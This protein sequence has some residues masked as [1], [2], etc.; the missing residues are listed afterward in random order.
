MRGVIKDAESILVLD[1]IHGGR[2]IEEELRSLGKE[3]V[4]MNPYRTLYPP[5]RRFD[6]IISP[7][8]LNPSLLQKILMR[9]RGTRI[10]D[11]RTADKGDEG[12]ERSRGTEEDGIAVITHHDAV[13]EI[14]IA[15]S[16]FECV[17][18]VVEVTG[19]TA[20][21]TV[22]EMIS[23]LLSPNRVLS[24]TSAGFRYW[25]DERRTLPL[26]LSIT[27]ASILKAM[28]YAEAEGLEVENAIFEVSLGLTGIGDVGVITTLHPDYKIA[29][30]TK[31]ASDAKLSSLRNFRGILV[32]S[33]SFPESA[34]D[35]VINIASKHLRLFDD[36]I[37]AINAT[38]AT[39]DNAEDELLKAVF[40]LK[41]LKGAIKGNFTFKC[42]MKNDFYR[43]AAELA[44]TA[45]LSLGVQPENL[46]RRLRAVDHRM[47]V[48]KFRGRILID[49]SNSGTNLK[50]LHH[51]EALA[52][53][54]AVHVAEG[55]QCRGAGDSERVL[56]I[57]EESEY[58][59]E[60]VDAEE[61]RSVIERKYDDFCSIIVVG[62]KF[63][64][65]ISCKREKIIVVKSLDEALD[66][67]VK[68]T[69]EGAIIIS[70]VKTWQ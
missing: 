54:A 41:T 8:H 7:V 33:E 59:C 65:V 25:C 6:L 9:I 15:T 5:P 70:N 47:S 32:T 60:G 53:T 24:L 2:I 34:Y 16:V 17:S 61:L 68:R 14:A 52:D 38:N 3:A 42:E 64:D 44:I 29:G 57:G 28:R 40:N 46:S 4:G 23:Q 37:N 22:C 66:N 21:T 19:T 27:P 35:G 39:N 10:H 67:A 30:N 26:R 49:N 18:A 12:D 55:E 69:R 50:F 31:N 11:T 1:T 45:A 13:R 20:K 43:N 56:I 62:E 51:A 63:R 48:K 58:V 36:A